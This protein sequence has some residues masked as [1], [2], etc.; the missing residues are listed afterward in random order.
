MACLLCSP[1]GISAQEMYY[2]SNLKHSL[3]RYQWQ[4]LC[5]PPYFLLHTKNL[6][7]LK[8]HRHNIYSVV[9]WLNT[10]TKFL[11]HLGSLSFIL[12]L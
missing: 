1:D 9:E 2:P 4:P 11:Q 12:M 7:I 6:S 8:I 5:T 3:Q 10:V